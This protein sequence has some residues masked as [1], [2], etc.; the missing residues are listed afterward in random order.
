MMPMDRKKLINPFSWKRSRSASRLAVYPKYILPLVGF[1]LHGYITGLS[2][3]HTYLTLS[4][5]VCV[6]I[7]QGACTC[8]CACNEV[9]CMHACIVCAC[10]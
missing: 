8:V 5:R 7:R 10:M 4:L 1:G 3:A 6:Y 2:S 9:P